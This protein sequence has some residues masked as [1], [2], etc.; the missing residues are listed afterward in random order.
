MG[1]VCGVRARRG[2]RC[3][4]Q[5]CSWALSWRVV[6][7]GKGAKGQLGVP[8]V[9]GQL[10]GWKAWQRH[11]GKSSRQF[12][13]GAA[14]LLDAL[15]VIAFCFYCG[16]SPAARRF[17]PEKWPS[18]PESEQSGDVSEPGR[19]EAKCLVELEPIHLTYYYF[20]LITL[21]P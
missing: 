8:Q 18:S 4:G 19:M 16:L 14:E 13:L 1:R 2:E 12:P 17:N 11:T 6:S 20:P 21:F 7:D 5:R 3:N 15:E 10:V 9:V